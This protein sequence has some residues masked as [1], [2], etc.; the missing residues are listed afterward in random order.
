LVIYQESLQGA[1]QQNVKN[2]SGS[3]PAHHQEFYTVHSALVYVIQFWWLLS[4]RTRAELLES[5]H[6]TCM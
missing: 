2:V 6:Q 5:G 1:G 3:S 4:G